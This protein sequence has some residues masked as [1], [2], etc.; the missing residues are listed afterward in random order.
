M[1]FH[2]W[3]KSLENVLRREE[4]REREREIEREGKLFE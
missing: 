1:C 3:V 2:G 4:G